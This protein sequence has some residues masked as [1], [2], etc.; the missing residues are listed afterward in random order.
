MPVTL[1]ERYNPAWPK[2]F[3]TILAHLG[4]EI[5]DAC[6]RIDHVGS[7]AVPGMTAKPVID[8]DLVI[9]DGEFEMIQGLLAS[10]GYYHQGNLGQGPVS[11]ETNHRLG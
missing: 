3:E 8:L 6:L 2:W 1:V 9:G 7:T 11:V 10:R 4:Q 5:N